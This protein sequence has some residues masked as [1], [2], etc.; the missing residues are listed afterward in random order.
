MNR[1]GWSLFSKTITRSGDNHLKE[2]LIWLMMLH[3]TFN[4]YCLRIGWRLNCLSARNFYFIIRKSTHTRQFRRDVNNKWLDTVSNELA[5]FSSVQ[6]LR[7]S[8]SVDLFAWSMEYRSKA[9]YHTVYWYARGRNVN[10][11][12]HFR[13][14]AVA[15]W[16]EPLTYRQ[17]VSHVLCQRT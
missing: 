5:F 9:S 15:R 17:L 16:K 8:N 11:T 7:F 12:L 10:G 1:I 4:F 6:L 3:N 2:S 14:A 13:S